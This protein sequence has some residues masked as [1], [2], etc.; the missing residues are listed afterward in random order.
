ML[1][2]AICLCFGQLIWKIMP[3]Y[4]PLYLLIGFAIYI[5]G[6]LAMIFAYRYGELS[7]LQPINSVSYVF[8]TIIAIFILHEEVSLLNLSGIVLIVGGIIVIGV[9][10]K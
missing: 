7:V 9:N 10:N 8:S 4:N 6:A 3:G 2:C 1:I 5:A